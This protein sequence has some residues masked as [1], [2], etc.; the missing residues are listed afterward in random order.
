MKKM[1]RFAAIAAAAA[2]TACMA[3]PMTAMLSASAVDYTITIKD[4]DTANVHTYEAYQIFTGALADGVLSGI[5]WGSGVDTTGLVDA[6]KA[7]ELATAV[8]YD[9][10]DETKTSAKPFDAAGVT[11]AADIA[12][13]LSVATAGTTGE[14]EIAKAFADVVGNYLGTPLADADK[15]DDKIVTTQAG[16]YLI[17]DA[18]NSA[19]IAKTR[20]ILKVV[21]NVDIT[22]KASYPNVIKK[23]QEET[24]TK[25][26]AGDGDTVEEAAFVGVS[27]AYKVG[28]G[29][30]DVADYDI[31]DAVPFRLYGSMPSTLT[32]YD[33]YYYKFTD[34]LGTQFNEPTD[35]TVKIVSKTGSADADGYVVPAKGGV[36]SDLLNYTYNYD[37]STG[38]TLEFKDVRHLRDK[39]G[40][41][42]AVDKDSIVVVE[43]NAVLNKTANVGYEG[44]VNAVYLEYSKN[45][46]EE[47]KPWGDDDN[48]NGTKDEGENTGDDQNFDTED[49]TETSEQ[50]KTKEDGVVVFTYGFDINKVIAGS[51]TK[52]AG[53][54]FAVYYKNGNDKVYIKTDED[55]IYAGNLTAPPT[56]ETDVGNA[57]GVWQSAEEGNIV[58]KGLDKDKQYF[59]EEL[60]AP[61]TYNPLDKDVAVTIGST[62]DEAAIYQQTWTYQ[63]TGNKNQQ[64]AYTALDEIT[65]QQG[66]DNPV[67]VTDNV[68]NPDTQG[69]TEDATDLGTIKIENSKGSSLPSTGGIGTTLFYVIGGTLAAGAGVGLIA[70]KRMKNE[71]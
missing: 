1:R 60:A 25:A 54:K 22:E 65:I 52:L 30:N 41:L 17:Q 39:S 20:Y 44:Q 23:V 69:V 27:D 21:D 55:N 67:V 68:D 16:Y 64:G 48:H 66:E 33:Y 37:A 5:E 58:I 34:T 59:V 2:M 70:K 24:L 11:S 40:N 29:Y 18:A 62:F 71:D 32:D 13:V 57:Y 12:K 45:P 15:T 43:Y 61:A 53:A 56:D 50:S 10:A 31:G 4:T 26:V 3:M 42:I 38:F 47:Y 35:L 36:N 6:V 19:A 7:I 51:E 8:K 49:T 28:D 14:Q 9:E 46:N 63:A